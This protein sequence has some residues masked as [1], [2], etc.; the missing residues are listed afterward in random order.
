M[1][2]NMRVQIVAVLTVGALLGCLA[3]TGAL[4]P[5]AWADDAGSATDQAGPDMLDRTVLPIP[6]P[7]PAAITEVDARK[8]KPPPRFQVKAPKGAPNVVVILLD[9]VGFGD[10][11][12]FGGPIQMPTLDRLAK[13]GLRYNNFKVPPLCSPS[14]MALLTGRNSHSCNFGMIAEM[15]TAFPGNTGMRPSSIAMLPEILRLNG[16]NTAMFGKCHELG[17]G[18]PASSGR[19]TAGRCIAGLRGSTASCPARPTSFIRSCTTT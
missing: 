8:V 17:P 9:N 4:N 18:K 19:S 3:A 16:Y 2:R 1:L 14:R 10:L 15:A 12:T 6:E 11:S 5:C 7:E 13:T